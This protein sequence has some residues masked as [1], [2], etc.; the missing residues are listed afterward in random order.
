MAVKNPSKAD[1]TLPVVGI[2]GGHR[3]AFAGGAV[4]TVVPLVGVH[5]VWEEKKKTTIS[6]SLQVIEDETCIR[7][8]QWINEMD[9]TFKK[10]NK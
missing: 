9:E 5:W 2:R 3:G 1:C 10:I 6:L 4:I 8:Q 7:M